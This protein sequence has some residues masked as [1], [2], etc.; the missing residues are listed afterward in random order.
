MTIPKQENTAELEE[1]AVKRVKEGLTPGA[2]AKEL[3][4]IEQM[5]RHWVK[6]ADAGKLNG[7]DA[8]ADPRHSCRTQGRRRQRQD[9]QG[10]A[11]SRVL[12]QP[13]KI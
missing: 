4:L 1:L 9:G 6:A 13:G 10:T 7:P 8:D 11:D 5:L 2:A 12:R 3:G